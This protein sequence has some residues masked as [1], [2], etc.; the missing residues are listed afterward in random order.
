MEL[1]S[2]E[3]EPLSGFRLALVH[4]PLDELADGA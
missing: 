1:A 3:G 2:E 4:H